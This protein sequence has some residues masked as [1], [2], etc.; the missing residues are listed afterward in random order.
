[1]DGNKLERIYKI[2]LFKKVVQ[3]IYNQL[4]GSTLPLFKKVVQNIYNQLFGSTFSK[5]GPND[6]QCFY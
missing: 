2:P 1:M 4:F 5:G 3:N 6:V